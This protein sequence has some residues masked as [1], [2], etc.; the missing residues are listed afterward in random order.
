MTSSPPTEPTPGV[1]RQVRRGG[2]TSYGTGRVCGA[3]AC[4]TRLSI[5][6]EQTVCANHTRSR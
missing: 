6:N 2:V 4:D 5:Y 1:E 3:A